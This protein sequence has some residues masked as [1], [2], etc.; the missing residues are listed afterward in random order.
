MTSFSVTQISYLFIALKKSNFLM[1]IYNRLCYLQLTTFLTSKCT[2]DFVA[3][4]LSSTSF[5]SL[6]AIN[7]NL[8]YLNMKPVS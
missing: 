4:I 8:F 2:P 6:I 7:Y 5:F 1:Q 3:K